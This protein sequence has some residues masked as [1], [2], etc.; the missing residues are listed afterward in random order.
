MAAVQ[1]RLANTATHRLQADSARLASAA[2][3]LHHVSPLAILA[4]GYAL[5][6]DDAG[7]VLSRVEDFRA[8]QTIHTR[9]R[10]VRIESEVR[11]VERTAPPAADE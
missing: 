4:R 5:I 3:A 6:E 11:R 2:R 9:V 10:D 1:S 7:R 8:G